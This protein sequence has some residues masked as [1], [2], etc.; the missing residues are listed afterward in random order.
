MA[1]LT[2]KYNDFTYADVEAELQD[3]FAEQ[4]DLQFVEEI[5][6]RYADPDDSDED[7]DLEPYEWRILNIILTVEPFVDILHARMNAE[8]RERYDVLMNTRGNRQYIISPFAFNWLPYISSRY[9]WR[10]HPITGADDLHTGLDIAVASGTEILAGHDGTVRSA[11]DAGAYGLA[12]VIDGEDGLATRYAHCSAL[13]VTAGQEVEKGDVIAEVG[14]TGM[15]TGP[16][17]HVEV[18]KDGRFLNPLLFAEIE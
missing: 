4:Y 1:V 18:I 14:S 8:Q 13:S 12:V 11:G 16:H 2:A 6:T 3:I 5:E 17:L 9:G 15:S 10:V 7:G